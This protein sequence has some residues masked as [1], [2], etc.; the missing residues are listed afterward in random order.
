MKKLLLFLAFSA[1]VANGFAQE[2]SRNK[3]SFV[4][5]GTEDRYNTVRVINHSSQTN[6]SCRVVL[7]NE[8]NSI[9]SVYGDYF[10]KG[11][12]DTDSNTRFFHQGARMGI[13]MMSDFDGEVTFTVEYK[14]Y[15]IYDAVYIHIYD[16]D[17]GYDESF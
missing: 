15:P 17:G 4:V 3:M 9:Q 2:T 5:E 12:G 1:M 6:F 7:L 10:L 14:D 13:Q 11:P 8:D 16:A